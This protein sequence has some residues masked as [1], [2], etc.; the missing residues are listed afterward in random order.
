MVGTCNTQF[1]TSL[2]DEFAEL[3]RTI[4]NFRSLIAV[5][6]MDF[7]SN[8]SIFPRCSQVQFSSALKFLLSLDFRVENPFSVMQGDVRSQRACPLV[9]GMDFFLGELAV[10][11]F[12]V[13]AG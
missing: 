5:L 12:E 10:E 8:L 13:L 3:F 6:F 11:D 7:L 1:F 9:E 4:D 2:I